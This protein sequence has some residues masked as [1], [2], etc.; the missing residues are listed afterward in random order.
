G[1]RPPQGSQPRAGDG[2]LSLRRFSDARARRLRWRGHVPRAAGYSIIHTTPVQSTN[3]P[4][5]TGEGL[6]AVEKTEH[7]FAFLL[8]SSVEPRPRYGR[9]GR[10]CRAVTE[11]SGGG[12]ARPS[13]A[14]LAAEEGT[15]VRLTSRARS[16]SSSA[17]V[18]GGR[19]VECA[20]VR[21]AVNA[22]FADAARFAETARFVRAAQRT[23][24]PRRRPGGA[25]H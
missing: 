14:E 5:L 24:P 4:A 2:V 6:P 9:Y 7:T 22:R 21:L 12:A 8:T 15:Y 3:G 20:L 10:S 19:V 18:K 17:A 16:P 11:G 23:P 1:Y 13:K 25:H